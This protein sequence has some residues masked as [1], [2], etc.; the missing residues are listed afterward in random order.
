MTDQGKICLGFKVL[1]LK[2]KAISPQAM[3]APTIEREVP[4]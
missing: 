3:M 2:A 4:S 1:M